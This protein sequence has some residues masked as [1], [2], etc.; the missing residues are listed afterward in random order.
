ME[1]E[2]AVEA[3]ACRELLA[4]VQRARDTLERVR[5]IEGI[6]NRF[7]VLL[8]VTEQALDREINAFK[9]H[10]GHLDWSKK[11]RNI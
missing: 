5:A 11:G 7:Q 1:S 2:Y 6:S 3:R 10:Y 9:K 4:D 8:R